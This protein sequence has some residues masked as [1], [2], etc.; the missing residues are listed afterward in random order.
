MKGTTQASTYHCTR[1]PL[2]LMILGVGS[3]LALILVEATPFSGEF[4]FALYAMPGLFVVWAVIGIW[5]GRLFIRARRDSSKWSRFHGV[6]M[7]ASI[8]VMF[9]FFPFVRSCNYLGGLLRFAVTHS[10]YEQQVALLPADDKPRVAVF[11]WGGM[12]WASKGVV[13]DE[14]DE[15]AL[16]PGQQS[17]EW[18]ANP[19]IGELRCGNWNAHRLWSHYYLVAFPC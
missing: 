6:L 9:N 5:S 1:V 11:T 10:Y 19:H 12:L 17:A 13:Y 4:G 18:K 7:V 14:S 2:L 3:T 8:L 16:P 15:V